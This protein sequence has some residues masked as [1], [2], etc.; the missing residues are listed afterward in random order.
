MQ[1]EG[2]L[3]KMGKYMFVLQGQKPVSLLCYEE[4]WVM[5]EYNSRPNTEPSTLNL[6]SKK[7]IV[8]QGVPHAT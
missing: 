4:V 7:N 6:A 3:E 5:K 8:V 2:H 1:R